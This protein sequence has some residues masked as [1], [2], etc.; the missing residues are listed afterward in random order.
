MQSNIYL[1]V[2]NGMEALQHK[3]QLLKEI[4]KQ[5]VELEKPLLVLHYWVLLEQL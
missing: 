2:L 1:N 4:L 3:K 5:K